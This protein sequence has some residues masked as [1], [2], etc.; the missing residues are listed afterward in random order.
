M[1]SGALRPQQVGPT[2]TD[3]RNIAQEAVSGVTERLDALELACAG[4]WDLLKTKHGY[5]DAE[6][7]AAIQVVDGRDGTVDGKV[8]HATEACP[9]CKRAPLVRNPKKCSWCG[10]ELVRTPL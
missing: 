8:S 4:L 9:Y 2:R 3:T 7:V 10:A 6:L 1:I 5:T